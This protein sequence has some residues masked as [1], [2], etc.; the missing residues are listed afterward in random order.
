MM[1][2]NRVLRRFVPVVLVVFL[3]SSCRSL[4]GPTPTP[5]RP[6]LPATQPLLLDRSP[7]RGEEAEL[8]RSIRLIF[9]QPMDPVTTEAAFSIEPAV[10]GNLSWEDPT[11]LVF[12]PRS[13]WERATRY[14][15]KL[16]T[17][18]KSSQGLA[19]REGV[20]FTFA[21]VG[22][23]EVTQVIPADETADV[24]PAADITV[25]FNRPV[26]P[27]Q[28]VSTPS[29]DLPDPLRFD[30]PVEGEGEWVNTSIY[31]F[32][33]ETGLTPGQTYF[34]VVPAGLSDTTG[35]V[36]EEGY[37]WR[38]TVQPP[39]VLRT[40]PSD[41]DGE[42]VLTQP[43]T[44]TFSQPMERSSTEAAFYL[45][46]SFGERVQGSFA[47]ADDSTQMAFIP[48]KAADGTGLALDSFYTAGVNSSARAATGDAT[49]VASY[50]WS[51]RTVF[52]PSIISTD[53]EDGE[54]AA[55]PSTSFRIYF[56]APM[57]VSTLM[58]NITILPEPTD[59]YTY[60][61]RYNNRFSVSWDIEPSTSYEV[62]LSA[63]MADPYG[64]TIGEDQVVRFTT[65]ALPP[66]TYL[67]VPGD[68]GSYNAYTDTKVYL[69]H[70]NVSQID[71]ELYR[72]DREQ[73]LALTGPERWQE[74]DTFVPEARAELMRQWTLPAEAELN[75][76]RYL[77]V[78]LVEGGGA[79]LPGL[80]YLEASAPEMRQREYWEP[81]GHILVVS[82]FHL[83][84]KLSQREVL[85]WATDLATGE[86]VH[87]LSMD[88]IDSSGDLLKG[89][90]T[91]SDG[92]F[93]TQFAPI[94]DIW[95]PY[96][97]FG[98]HVGHEDFAVAV[99]DWYDGI[100]PWDFGL[101]SS[102][103]AQPYRIYL[104]TDRPIYRPGQPVYFRGVVREEYDAR[105]TMP[106][107]V[108][109]VPVV[110]YDDQGQEI[111]NDELPLSDFGTFSG[112][113]TLDDEA[114]LGYYY[115]Q[116]EVDERTDGVG[117]QVA[118]YRRPEF[119]VEVVAEQDEVLAGET[120]D[121][122][123]EATYFF[124]GPVAEAQVYWT[125]LTQDLSFRPD[126][127]GWWDWSDTSRW[128]WWQPQEVPGWG[129]V[130][131]D[132]E[133]ITDDQ[134]RYLFS[135][136][137]DIADAI[138]SQQYTIEATVVD[139][140]DQTVSDRTSVYV[141]K[142]LYYI[143]LRPERYVG[144]V[145]ERQAVD[146][147][148]ADW[149][150]NLVGNRRLNVSFNRREWFNV[151]EEDEYGNL[152]WT[153]S[154]SD[155]VVFEQTVTTDADG[156]A[157]A[158]F[159]PEEG[160]TY[161]V[162]AE[163]TDERGNSI[164]SA[165]WLW[166]SSREYVS[167]R[168]ENNDRVQLIADSRSYEP[169]DVARILVPSPFQGEVTALFTVERGRV[170]HHWVQTLSGNAETIDLPITADYAP[171]VFVSVVLVKGVDEFNPVPAY[172]V[173]YVSF[174][175]ST[176][177]QELTVSVITDRDMEAGEH[178]GPRDTVTAEVLV[179]DGAGSPVEAEVGLAVVD[180]S[181]LSL[182]EPNSPAI[183]SA[184][185]GE[186]GL[187]IRTADNLSISVDRITRRVA[188]EAKG[189]GG[190]AAAALGAGEIRQDFPDTAF[191]SPSVR[192][193]AS[194]RATVSF[195]LP[196]QLTT[197]N[198]DARAVTV[199]TLVGQ[200]EIEFL[201]TK[202][203]LVRPVTPRFFVAGDQVD[204][205]A[206]VHNN[207]S[208]RLEVEVWLEATGVT[209]LGDARHSLTVPG[210]GNARVEW[211]VEVS[212]AAGTTSSWVDLT[213][214]AS[215]GGYSDAVKPP[216]G[217]PPEQL[218]PVY[219]YS[220]PETVGTSGQLDQAE[221]VLEAVA[222]P[223]VIDTTQGELTV[224]IEPSLAAGMVG[225]LEYL[226]HFPYECTEQV[227]SR[228]LPNILTYRALEELGLEDVEL[229]ENL[230]EQVG[231]GLQRLYAR[232]HYD[233]GW[234]WWID[235]SS[236]TLISAYVVFGL[237]K[238]QLAGFAVD[239]GVI[240][241]GA[242]FLETRLE[243]TSQLATTYQANRQ[244]FVLYAL[245]QAGVVEESSLT[246][247]YEAR[248]LLGHYGKAYLALAFGILDSDDPRIDTLL[249]DL[250]SAAIVSATGAHWQES[251]RSSWNWNTDTRTT[252][253]VLSLLAQLDPDNSLAPNVVRWLMHARTADHWETTQETAWAL[254]GL[255]DWMVATGELEG[256][257]SWGVR[258]N[259]DEL[260]SGQVSPQTVQDVTEFRTAIADLLVGESNRL[261]IARG[262]GEGRLYYTAHLRAFLPAEEV[263][264]L[265]RGIVVG[266][267]YYAADCEEDCQPIDEA[268]VGDLVRVRLTVIAPHDLNY[269]IVEDPFPAGAEPVDTSLQT[270]SVVDTAPEFDRTD[271]DT[272]WW[273]RYW[274][275][276][277]F[278]NTDLRD[279][280]LVL[281]ATYLPAGTY[282]YTYL[283]QVG[284]AGEYRALP[285]TAYEMYFPE[286]MGRSD[287]MLFS[288][289]R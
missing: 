174:D 250:N 241:R 149:D 43:I 136:P 67:A 242:A 28:L 219:S 183:L 238:A 180:E 54:Y 80:Y 251:S 22:Y 237:A 115:I 208:D 42:I 205:A 204:L 105:Y 107:D 132:G 244:A 240:E 32:R 282:E 144:Q 196:D 95:D 113:F 277:W 139:V 39:Y 17:S 100:G 92:V 248:G 50:S 151:Q 52:Y 201:S 202:D 135:V 162:R 63:G 286:V 209:M 278:S 131:A 123:V 198:V 130:I 71:L 266:R 145:G 122:A 259:W 269:V 85:I 55:D 64:N 155:T 126:V 159:V 66:L 152:Y 45:Q 10:A 20:D 215:G 91:D 249:S 233:G 218:L 271:V 288:I 109:S 222:L 223:R 103:S 285:T 119:E 284:L 108:E 187:G 168:Q 44:V 157:Q 97:V 236:N 158:S 207:T 86:P 176:V 82:R 12:T 234:G 203:L 1:K 121:I 73:F 225:G 194:G 38:F 90:S 116:S 164:V 140:N 165:T 289:E 150:G 143:G 185:Y 21:T 70:R 184:F 175:V 195:D 191:W 89:G 217:L 261:E 256:D 275:W 182:A 79:L 243:S 74:W 262:E 141:H 232:Q 227:V 62:L 57:D 61:S 9:D 18:A 83:T 59:V 60:W 153:W 49:L 160:G 93:T 166:V 33:P 31:V 246:L 129:R 134:G 96:T 112:E 29:T 210:G 48:R 46:D 65:D 216:A 137:A 148:T 260:G 197:W 27:L 26:V 125:L 264:A 263:Q 104:Y 7:A 8:D 199:D 51:F 254:I 88:L 13:D 220:A 2:A 76:S 124:G 229:E 221:S 167:W 142:G 253:V 99:S 172:R 230:E 4:F 267:S 257:Y 170:L 14:Q 40:E 72:L 101:P 226:E 114:G 213:F 147:L 280:K 128:D 146:V 186:R 206:V 98:G 138:F 252:A 154:P 279:E 200:T 23:L 211:P 24:D 272:P 41:G 192:T 181:V 56:S 3:L 118:E 6:P 171:N 224:R 212:Q 102:M 193:D 69:A 11:T 190:G 265:S 214:Y 77:L 245:A 169:G 189:G 276:W 283:L 34:V 258:L 228:F 273:Y 25:M 15:V 178:Y 5:T 127:P 84:L 35:G 87:G 47:W 58:P 53:P 110:V 163:G 247:L 106:Q 16:D 281:F 68:V 188:A 78:D 173:G 120:V 19:M 274:S 75:D 156:E 30:P 235:D 239:P 177:E 255:T 270:T 111:Y 37:S 81:A 161:I 287:G 133:G 179:T 268:R 36:L 117:F 231:V 94:E